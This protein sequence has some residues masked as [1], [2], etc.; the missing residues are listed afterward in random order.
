MLKRALVK[1]VNLTV[2]VNQGN[3][4]MSFSD[5]GVLNAETQAGDPAM[6]L[7]S[8]RHRIRVLGGTLQVSRTKAGTT[9]L[10]VSMPL[11]DVLSD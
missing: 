9:V 11:P 10:T 5:D 4:W 3:F 6:I 1:S 8:M 7:A 2:S